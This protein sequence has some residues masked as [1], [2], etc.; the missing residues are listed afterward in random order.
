MGAETGERALADSP[1]A[2]A[3]ARPPSADRSNAFAPIS[4]DRPDQKPKPASESIIRATVIFLRRNL[5]SIWFLGVLVLSTRLAWGNYLFELQLRRRRPIAEPAVLA[6]FEECRQTMDIR[7]PLT[8]LE[9]PE[10]D[11]PALFGCFRLKLLLPEK[12]IEAFSPAELRHVFLHELAHIRRWDAA[13]NWLTTILQTLHWFNPALWFAF[14]RMRADREVACDELALARA[15]EAESKPYGQ[16]VLKVLEGFTGPT[17]IPGLV[18]ILEDKTQIKRRI[19]MIAQFKKNSAWP[20]LATVVLMGLGLGSLTDAQTQK[21][22]EALAGK[23]RLAPSRKPDTKVVS[24]TAA[25][26]KLGVPPGRILSVSPDGRYV[27]F[28]PRENYNVDVYETNTGKTWTAV[29]GTAK[30]SAWAGVVFSA[31]SSQIAYTLNESIYTAKLDGTGAKEIYKG[32]KDSYVWLVDWLLDSRKLIAVLSADTDQIGTIAIDGGEFTEIK[33]LEKGVNVNAARLSSNGRYL[34]IRVGG[35]GKQRTNI[36]VIEIESNVQSTVIEGNVGTL[37]GWEPG[38]SGILFLSDR[39]GITGLWRINAQPNE[40]VG[41]PELLKANLGDA[42]MHRVCRDGSIYFSEQKSSMDAYVLAADFQTG[43]VLNQ[44]R[45]ATERFTGMKG[46]PVWSKDGKKLMFVVAHGEKRFAALS[47]DSGEYQEF[48]VA[49]IFTSPLQK[50]AWS[51]DNSVMYIQSY[52]AGQSHGIHRYEIASG[53]TETFVKQHKDGKGWNCHPRLSPNGKS[54][55]YTRRIFKEGNEWKD[56]IVRHDLP[57]GQEEIVAELAE[58][59]NIW[60]PFELSPDG[61][62]LALVMSDQFKNDDFT[63]ALRILPLAGGAAKE[64]FRTAPRENI[65]SLSWTPDGKRLVFTKQ[66]ES[67]EKRTDDKS[68]LWSLDIESGKT[69]QIGLHLPRMR[70]VSVHPDGRRVVLQAGSS[71]GNGQDVWVMEDLLLK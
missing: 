38:D 20:V 16:T 59:I 46:V 56:H 41:N 68:E 27:G 44:P 5:G 25:I 32:E 31:D 47:L 26:R 30:K 62:R 37:V 52:L 15:N 35:D 12:M 61:T 7:R 40:P 34:A 11:G 51:A 55:Y 29:K 10:L 18:G 63:V 6:L 1:E 4:G 22:A 67:D 13:V 53:A 3:V 49:K 58:K 24:E 66:F 71:D 65:N 36:S 69:V 60:W 2:P 42:S 70:E 57:S 14:H 8:L 54:L 21:G 19:H 43:E 50:Y 39:A 17:A 28:M 33:R 9:A 64:L 23:R 45:P 48:P